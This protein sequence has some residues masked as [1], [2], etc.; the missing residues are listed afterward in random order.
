LI[1]YSQLLGK[2]MVH[3]FEIPEDIKRYLK[4]ANSWFATIFVVCYNMS[5]D[6]NTC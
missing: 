6:K 1:D 2:L 4:N 5:T 3:L